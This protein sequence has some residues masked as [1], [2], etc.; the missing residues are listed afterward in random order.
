MAYNLHVQ[1]ATAPAGL[2]AYLRVLALAVQMI[3]AAW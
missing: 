1:Q 2:L 3:G